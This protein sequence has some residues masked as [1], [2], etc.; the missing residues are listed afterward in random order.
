MPYNLGSNFKV[1]TLTARNHFFSMFPRIHLQWPRGW[2]K[3]ADS[4]VIAHILKATER[5]RKNQ[6]TQTKFNGF[7]FCF[8][9][10]IYN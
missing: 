7:V 8:L 3:F 2:R 4:L 1:Q 6:T 9:M 10:V 5:K